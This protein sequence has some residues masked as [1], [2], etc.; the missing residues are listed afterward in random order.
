MDRESTRILLDTADL[1]DEARKNLASLKEKKVMPFSTLSDYLGR[2]RKLSEEIE[3][4]IHLDE[5]GN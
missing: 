1:I 5:C 4:Q 2:L 3:N